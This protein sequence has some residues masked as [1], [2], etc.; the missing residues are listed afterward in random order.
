MGK[1][2]HKERVE[3]MTLPEIARLILSEAGAPL[4]AHE[5]WTEAVSRGLA[6]RAVTTAERPETALAA[7]LYKMAKKGNRGI[8]GEGESPMR[9][10]LEGG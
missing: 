6:G 4:S 7:H 8:V 1:R 10:R 2:K 9:F 5:V 3:R